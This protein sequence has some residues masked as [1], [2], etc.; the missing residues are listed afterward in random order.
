V[1]RGSGQRRK[2]LARA[3]VYGLLGRAFS[4]PDDGFLRVLRRGLF[5]NSLREAVSELG[6]EYNLANACE[7]IA[8]AMEQ[9]KAVDLWDEYQEL[10]GIGSGSP[11]YE[12]EY[13]RESE[14]TK[15]NRLADIAGFYTAFGLRSSRATRERIDHIGAEME[16][17][18]IL[19]L[20]Q[21]RALAL[22]EEESAA[23]C[24]E[25]Q[26]KFLADHLLRWAPVFTALVAKR[27]NGLYG[28]FAL[29][30]YAFFEKER[31]KYGLSEQAG[32]LLLGRAPAPGDDS[33]AVPTVFA[34]ERI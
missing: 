26:S 14:F 18:Q 13:G 24:A 16:F 3:K 31:M 5:L 9:S 33:C 11:C 19:L 27:A 7:V 34:F 23:I 29:F 32:G 25:A 22:G 10:F 4:E 30:A 2:L 28:A 17:M 21:G 12:M 1:G 15:A 6:D 8:R 20:K